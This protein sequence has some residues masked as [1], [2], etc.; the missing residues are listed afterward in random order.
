LADTDLF[1][2]TISRINEGLNDP[3]EI[4]MNAHTVT[5]KPDGSLWVQD[6]RFA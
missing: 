5:L 3:P 6:A 4:T 1:I 2:V